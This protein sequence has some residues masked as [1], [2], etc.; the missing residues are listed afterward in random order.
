MV[1]ITTRKRAGLGNELMRLRME[2]MRPMN[3]NGDKKGEEGGSSMDVDD[4]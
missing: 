4:K 3:P 2:E 1:V